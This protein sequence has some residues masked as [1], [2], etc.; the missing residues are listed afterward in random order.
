MI[1]RHKIQA[2]NATTKKYPKK[3]YNGKKLQEQ[4]QNSKDS[5]GHLKN[6]NAPE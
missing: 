1:K 6:A 2:K 4:S 3:L 5:K